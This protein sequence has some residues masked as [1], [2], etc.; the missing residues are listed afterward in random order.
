MS[1]LRF[2]ADSSGVFADKFIAKTVSWYPVGW[3]VST[4]DSIL[5]KIWHVV[6]RNFT[7]L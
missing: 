5:N 6:E 3:P 1:L 7:N 2:L 4:L